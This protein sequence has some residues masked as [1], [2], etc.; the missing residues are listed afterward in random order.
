[1]ASEKGSPPRKKPKA[2]AKAAAKTGVKR[3]SVGSSA[4]AVPPTSRRRKKSPEEDTEKLA[5][6]HLES[7]AKYLE[8]IQEIGVDCL[9]RNLVRAAEA[10]FVHCA[11]PVEIM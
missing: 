9:W 11:D 2:S 6:G 4:S 1:M 3:K 8:S 7:A 5:K 10:G